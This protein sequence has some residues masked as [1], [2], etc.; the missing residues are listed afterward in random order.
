MWNKVRRTQ[1][2]QRCHFRLMMRDA[3]ANHFM[4]TETSVTRMVWSSNS[5]HLSTPAKMHTSS[6]SPPVFTTGGR[7]VSCR[8]P[9][10]DTSV[11]MAE[12]FQKVLDDR[13]QAMLFHASTMATS[14][15]VPFVQQF[16]C[17]RGSS[18]LFASA[19]TT[20]INLKN[21]LEGNIGGKLSTEL[22]TQHCHTQFCA[23]EGVF[24]GNTYMV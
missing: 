23:I 13:L 7:Q 10:S 9:S 2:L 16:Q 19:R 18:T 24:S 1:I 15:D 6:A 5:Y 4:M 8:L 20:R 14:A 22:E 12:H 17:V 11:R 3:E 21:D